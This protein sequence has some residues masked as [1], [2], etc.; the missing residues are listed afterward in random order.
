VRG[1]LLGQPKI[2]KSMSAERDLPFSTWSLA[3]L[4][5]LLVAEV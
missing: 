4:A 3:K 2:A 5:E 1:G